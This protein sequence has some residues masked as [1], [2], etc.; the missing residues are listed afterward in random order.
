M[1]EEVQQRQQQRQQ[2]RQGG[3]QSTDT[4]MRPK[5]TD[6]ICVYKD[7]SGMRTPLFIVE[8][9]LPHKLSV[10]ISYGDSARIWIYEKLLSGT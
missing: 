5:N 1:S 4:S 8:Y 7:T 3:G 10:E 6:Q 9:K 2:R